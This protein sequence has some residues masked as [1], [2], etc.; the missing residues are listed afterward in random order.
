MTRTT[1][2][3]LITLHFSQIF[4]TLALTFMVLVQLAIRAKQK[5]GNSFEQ[6][7]LGRR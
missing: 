1:P 2:R 3:R 7:V 5:K 4:L 6:W